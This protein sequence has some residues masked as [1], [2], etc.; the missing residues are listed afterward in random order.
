VKLCFG[1]FHLPK[2]FSDVFSNIFAVG[3]FYSMAAGKAFPAI[4]LS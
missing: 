2:H 4:A 3:F 1:I